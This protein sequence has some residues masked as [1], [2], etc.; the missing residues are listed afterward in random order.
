LI[1]SDA[2]V[3]LVDAAAEVFAAARWRRCV[4]HWYRNVQPGAERQGGGRARIPEAFHA[5][6]DRPAAAKAW[7]AGRPPR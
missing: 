5:Q 7:E 2:C 1:I 4:M 6:E 3:G